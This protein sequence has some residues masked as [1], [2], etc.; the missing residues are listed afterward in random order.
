MVSDIVILKDLP[1]FIKESL[2]AYTA[3]ISGAMKRGDYLQTIEASGFAD[4]KVID[5]NI[6]PLDSIISD[7]TAKVIMEGLEITGEQVKDIAN[8]ISSIKVQASNQVNGE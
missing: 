2:A 6:F 5:E 8:S 1:D 7:P 3:C 4:V